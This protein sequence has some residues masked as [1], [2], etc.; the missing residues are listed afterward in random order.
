MANSYLKMKDDGTKS[1]MNCEYRKRINP[2]GYI[3]DRYAL[4]HTTTAT[5]AVGQ[6]VVNN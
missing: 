5:N 3:V 2:G 6:V 4:R 1:L